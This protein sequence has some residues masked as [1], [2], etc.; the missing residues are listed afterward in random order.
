MQALRLLQTSGVPFYLHH[1]S[2]RL[3]QE[4][5]RVAHYLH[6]TTRKPLLQAALQKLL[7]EHVDTLIEKGFTALMD[8]SR[9]DD[10]AQ[11]HSLY[12]KV[13]ARLTTC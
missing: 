2:E 8:S 3:A 13:E 6:S 11:M 7:A 9:L 12:S 4:E 5:Q 1:V 10:L